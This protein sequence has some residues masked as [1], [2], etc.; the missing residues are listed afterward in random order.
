[1]PVVCEFRTHRAATGERQSASGCCACSRKGNK[2]RLVPVGETALDW[3]Q[4]T[5]A[6][7]VRNC[8]LLVA[9]CCSPVAVAEP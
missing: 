5:C 7:H 1:M 2:E 6:R 9:V 4:R 3:L 8:C